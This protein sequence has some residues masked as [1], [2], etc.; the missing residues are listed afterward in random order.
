M[1]YLQYIN[2]SNLIKPSL[3]FSFKPCYKWITFN[4]ENKLPGG[5][6]SDV[7]FKPCYKWITFNT[8]GFKVPIIKI[9]SSEVLNLVINGLPSIPLPKV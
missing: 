4:T 1:D 8:S 2:L 6:L 7:S 5:S 3:S 9:N